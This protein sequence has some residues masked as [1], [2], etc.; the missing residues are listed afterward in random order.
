MTATF[1]EVS[2]SALLKPRPATIGM[3]IVEKKLDPTALRHASPW[4]R[5]SPCGRSS[6]I[7]LP[8][9]KAFEIKGAAESDTDST[10]GIAPTL[11]SILRIKIKSWGGGYSEGGA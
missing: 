1:G 5:S 4:L 9:D 10:P 8:E 7:K 2:V 3:P 6:R 11:S